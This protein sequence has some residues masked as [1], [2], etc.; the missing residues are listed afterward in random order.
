MVTLMDVVRW[1]YPLPSGSLSLEQLADFV[2]L[3][4]FLQTLLPQHLR[5]LTS[6]SL[7]ASLQVTGDTELPV[8]FAGGRSWQGAA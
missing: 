4:E 1:R 5:S 6:P 8:L 7:P 2:V 3:S